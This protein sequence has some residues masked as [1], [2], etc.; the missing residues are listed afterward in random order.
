MD[1]KVFV[2][3]NFGN[4]YDDA[5]PKLTFFQNHIYWRLIRDVSD[6]VSHQF[7]YWLYRFNIIDKEC[8]DAGVA[9]RSPVIDVKIVFPFCL[10]GNPVEL[11]EWNDFILRCREIAKNVH[12]A[13]LNDSLTVTIPRSWKGGSEW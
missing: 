11:A 6:G 7:G 13:G 9:G 1:C 3:R 8:G 4:G 12:E 10:K 5:Y 2:R